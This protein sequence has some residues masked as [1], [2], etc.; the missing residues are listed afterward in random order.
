MA[1]CALLTQYLISHD[2]SHVNAV[3][4]PNGCHSNYRPLKR[5]QQGEG[6]ALWP[7]SEMIKGDSCSE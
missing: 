3:P 1:L 2:C 4:D 7:D 5:K 6:S